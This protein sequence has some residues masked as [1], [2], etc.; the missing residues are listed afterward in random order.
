MILI[1]SQESSL[2]TSS[3]ETLSWEHLGTTR[4]QETRKKVTARLPHAC[5]AAVVP[6]VHAC[7]AQFAGLTDGGMRTT[8]PFSPREK[9]HPI[10]LN[11]K[12][13]SA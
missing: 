12:G 6:M 11:C 1:M 4:Y 3:A 2:Q 7:H 13:F 5:P 10:D 8:M 9:L